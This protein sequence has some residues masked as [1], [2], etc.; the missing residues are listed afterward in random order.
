MMPAVVAVGVAQN[1]VTRPVT[2]AVRIALMTVPSMIA[3]GRPVS[4]L[5]RR[6]TAFARG[7]ERT[8]GLDG[9]LGIHLTPATSNRPPT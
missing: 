6:I 2:A 1:R 7:S 8:V 5:L 4:R 9:T 3:T